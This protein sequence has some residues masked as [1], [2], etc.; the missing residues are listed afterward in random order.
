MSPSNS[1]LTILEKWLQNWVKF[2]ISQSIENGSTSSDQSFLKDEAR[3][4]LPL[5]MKALLLT[6]DLAMFFIFQTLFENKTKNFFT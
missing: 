4:Q 6:L 1:S 2:F 5:K 3:I